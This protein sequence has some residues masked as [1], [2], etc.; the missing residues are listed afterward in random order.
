MIQVSHDLGVGV[1]TL[2]RWVREVNQHGR[3]AVF[4]G[5][6]RSRPEDEKYKK[7]LRENE[8]LRWERDILKK[9]LTI[10]SSR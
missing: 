6:G 2:E 1:S 4:P 10:F 3:E 9:A 8:I 7:L 5:K